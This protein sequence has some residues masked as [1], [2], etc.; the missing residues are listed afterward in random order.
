MQS[1]ICPALRKNKGIL[2]PWLMNP[3]PWPPYI[4]HSITFQVWKISHLNDMNWYVCQFAGIL[5]NVSFLHKYPGWPHKSSDMRRSGG[6]SNIYRALQIQY[7]P[8]TKQWHS[9]RENA[10]AKSRLSAWGRWSMKCM[11]DIEKQRSGINDVKYKVSKS[12][13]INL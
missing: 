5:Q 11:K 3:A 8:F 12:H 10:A 9:I 13:L 6:I 1:N 7:Y 4:P 2:G